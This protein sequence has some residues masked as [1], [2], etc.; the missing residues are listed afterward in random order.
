MHAIR[1]TARFVAVG[2][3]SLMPDAAIGKPPSGVHRAIGVEVFRASRFG[4]A[5][6]AHSHH[7]CA[8]CLNSHGVRADFA[9]RSASANAC[10]I[11]ARIFAAP[12]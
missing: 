7:A 3:L 11:G 10:P 9:P 2:W 12:R 1:G 5:V 6:G 4:R 8:A